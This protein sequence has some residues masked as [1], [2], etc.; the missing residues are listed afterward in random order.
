MNAMEHVDLLEE[1]EELRCQLY[2][3]SCDKDLADPEVVRMSQELDSLLNLYYRTCL[4]R[5]YR[6]VG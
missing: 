5:D 3:L 6:K 4:S 2:T 1:I